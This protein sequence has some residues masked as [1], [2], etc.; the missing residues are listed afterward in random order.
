MLLGLG[1]LLSSVPVKNLTK[2]LFLPFLACACIKL[3]STLP[4]VSRW[5][6]LT[7]LNKN[8]ELWSSDETNMASAI[9]PVVMGVMWLLL[10]VVQRKMKI[11][12][13]PLGLEIGFWGLIRSVGDLAA[14]ACYWWNKCLEIWFRDCWL[15]YYFI[16]YHTKIFVFVCSCIEQRTI[17]HFNYFG[18]S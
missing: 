14:S 13:S 17:N 11:K 18:L 9:R 15:I 3:R 5:I 8:S 12:R 2:I 7:Y 4:S 16:N 6:L 10:S 1:Y